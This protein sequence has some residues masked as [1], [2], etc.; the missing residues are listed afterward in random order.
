MICISIFQKGNWSE[1]IDVV[2]ARSGYPGFQ[3][4]Q[5]CCSHYHDLPLF[6]GAY[7]DRRRGVRGAVLVEEV[8]VGSRVGSL[9]W[10]V[11][12]GDVRGQ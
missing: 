11:L 4:M 9:R 2:L 3:H 7:G 8:A 5:D 12:A 10:L 6:I 1:D